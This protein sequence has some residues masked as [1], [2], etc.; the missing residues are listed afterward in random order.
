MR[1]DFVIYQDGHCNVTSKPSLKKDREG[2]RK[3]GGDPTLMIAH[4]P[5]AATAVRQEV[6]MRIIIDTHILDR[7]S[8]TIHEAEDMSALEKI[9]SAAFHAGRE[10][11]AL[12]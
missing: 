2:E 3:G 10:F 12:H 11:Q 4:I 8:K 1:V 5:C 6:A 9:V 7:R